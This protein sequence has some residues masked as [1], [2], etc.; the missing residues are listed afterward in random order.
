MEWICCRVYHGVLSEEW[1]TYFVNGPGDFEVFSRVSQCWWWVSW[2]NQSSTM[3]GPLHAWSLGTPFHITPTQLCISMNLY[4]PHKHH[5][6]HFMHLQT[7][8]NN[9]VP[10]HVLLA[11]ERLF[12]LTSDTYFTLKHCMASLLDIREP[13]SRV[14]ECNEAFAI[15]W[16]IY[17]DNKT[18]TFWCILTWNILFHIFSHLFMIYYI[19]LPCLM[20]TSWLISFFILTSPKLI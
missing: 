4:K 13:D 17:W 7:T 3:I 14:L 2:T 20:F 16:M 8:S 10:L 11:A 1:T 12:L 15:F 18:S 6:N 5:L 19:I 9:F